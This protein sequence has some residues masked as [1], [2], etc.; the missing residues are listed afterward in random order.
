MSAQVPGG[1][2]ELRARNTGLILTS[3]RHDG[4]GTRTELARRTG[5][6]KATVGTI[7]GALGDDGLVGEAGPIPSGRG[8]PGRPVTLTEGRVV[9]LG[10]EV[11]VDYVATVAMDLSGEVRHAETLPVGPGQQ[12]LDVV[13]QVVAD[14][15]ATLQSEGCRLVGLSAAV[16]GLVSAD[17][18]VVRWAPNLGWTDLDLAGALRS[19][20]GEEVGSVTIDNDANCAALAEISHGAARDVTS[21]LYLT[22]TVGIGAGLVHE[23][24]LVR[25]ASGFAGEVGHLPLGDPHAQCGC[26]R[27][28]CWEASIGLRA[29]L[30][31]VHMTEVRTP[32]ETALI[33]ADRAGDDPSVAA[34]LAE[35]GARLGRGLAVLSGIVDPEAIV[36]GGYFVP[37]APWLTPAAEQAMA[38]H[39]AFADLH[40][41]QI[42]LSPLGLRS[43][44]LGAAEQSLAGVLSGSAAA[45]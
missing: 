19:A 39:L 6:A 22:G 32:W 14:R 4:P 21:A 8:R 1:V 27:S 12:P 18:A 37:L 31:A 36:L 41:P 30:A 20:I 23:R 28:G 11:N 24:Q 17:G 26:G 25:G 44:A 7:V 2:E 29:M 38:A 45:G 42:R 3:L 40:L 9:G 13:L 5:L 34:G 10:V 16:P 33:V 15:S 43:A 35:I